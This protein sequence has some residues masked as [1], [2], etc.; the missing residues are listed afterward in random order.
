MAGSWPYL[1]DVT[2]ES[3]GPQIPALGMRSSVPLGGLG[4]G[5]VGKKQG[6]NLYTKDEEGATILLI[7]STKDEEEATIFHSTALIFTQ[8]L[9]R[10]A[11]QRALRRLAN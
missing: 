2:D 4:T 6:E 7:C 11:S 10:A 5:S 9:C 8:L 1:Y 3:K